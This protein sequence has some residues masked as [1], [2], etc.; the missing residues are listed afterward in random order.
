MPAENIPALIFGGGLV[1]FAGVVAWYQWTYRQP[2]AAADELSQTHAR[3]QLRRRLQ[4]SGMIALLGLLIPLGDMLPL[5][6]NSPVAFFV[7]WVALLCLTGWIVLLAIADMAS[8]KVFHG[9]AAKQ[10][11][12]QKRELEAELARYRSRSNG[13]AIHSDE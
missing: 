3:R 9:R 5:F 10:L 2:E 11:L 6:R 13:H 8:A 1:V 12:Q 4:V 7:F